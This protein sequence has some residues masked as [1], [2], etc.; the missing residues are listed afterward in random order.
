MPREAVR[1]SWEERESGVFKSGAV[2]GVFVGV[3]A[4]KGWS[5]VVRSVVTWG[6][7]METSALVCCYPVSHREGGGERQGGGETEMKKE[8]ERERT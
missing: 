3:G 2:R 8:G 1:E 4:G 6:D 5:M 7:C